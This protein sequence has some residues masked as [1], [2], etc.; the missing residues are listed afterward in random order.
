MDVTASTWGVALVGLGLISLLSVAQL[1]AVIR[2]R[3]QWTIENVYGGSPDNT[4]PAAYFAFNQAMA[5]AD[6]FL[7]APLQIAGSIGMLLGERWGFLLALM[8]SVPYWYTAVFLYVWDRDLASRRN[9]VGY[10]V[11][12]AIWPAFGIVEGV[13]CFVRLVE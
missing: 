2:P 3:A 4:D 7:W 1:I 8:A 13:Y 10:W 5:W 6:P 11:A 12:W 9:T